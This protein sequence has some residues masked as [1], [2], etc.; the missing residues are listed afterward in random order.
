MTDEGTVSP[1]RVGSLAFTTASYLSRDCV[2]WIL[3]PRPEEAL[4]ACVAPVVEDRQW[5][6]VGLRG[7]GCA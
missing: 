3:F 1:N 6:G 7:H 2:A 5:H 4:R